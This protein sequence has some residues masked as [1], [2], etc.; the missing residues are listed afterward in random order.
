MVLGGLLESIN[1]RLLE[2]PLLI[3]GLGWALVGY[4]ILAKRRAE[5]DLVLT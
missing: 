1:E 4:A 5:P 2:L 3:L